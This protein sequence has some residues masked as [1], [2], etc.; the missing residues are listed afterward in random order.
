MP[1]GPDV[2]ANSTLR[3]LYDSCVRTQER[4]QA[5]IT[6]N[7]ALDDAY[8][9][10]FDSVSDVHLRLRKACWHIQE[11]SRWEIEPDV[12]HVL[13]PEIRVAATILRPVVAEFLASESAAGLLNRTHSELR[14]QYVGLEQFSHPNR[15]VLALPRDAGGFDEPEWHLYL[16]KVHLWLHGMLFDYGAALVVFAEKVD[17]EKV[18]EIWTVVSESTSELTTLEDTIT[19]LWTNDGVQ[20]P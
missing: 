16:L 5:L 17:G 13:A 6:V 14:S 11:A 1:N 4:L 10:K 19:R 12:L 9:L 2:N 20:A 15:L 8:R 7:V 18:S 3:D